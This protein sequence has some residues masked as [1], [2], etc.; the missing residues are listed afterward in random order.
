MSQPGCIMIMP[1]QGIYSSACAGQRR[2]IVLSDEKPSAECPWRRLS[3]ALSASHQSA[4]TSRDED[5]A[6]LMRWAGEAG[7]IRSPGLKAGFVEG[8]RGLVATQRIRPNSEM[9]VVPSETSLVTTTDQPCPFPEYVGRDFWAKSQWY[10]RLALLLL[11]EKQMGTE[12]KLH[13]WISRLPAAF[14]TPIAWSASELSELQYPHLDETVG[15]QRREWAELHGSLTATSPACGITEE[16]LSWAMGV[17]YSRAFR[18]GPRDF[19]PYEG[20]GPKERL[21]ELALVAVLAGGYLGLGFGDAGQVANGALAVLI[22][23]PLRDF[24]TTKLSQLKRYALTPVVDLLNHD[25]GVE[26]DVSYNYFYGHFAV[27]TTRGWEA[28]EQVLISYGP[29]SNDELLQRYGFVE[30]DNPNDVYRIT[31]LLNKLS[32]LVGEESVRVL[33]GSGEVL[34]A[35]RPVD[36]VTLGRRGL[37]GAEEEAKV[38]PAFR[39]AVVR[40]DQLPQGKAAQISLKD[41]SNE[42]SPA[43]ERAARRTLR[44]LCIK[45]RE[46]FSTSIDEDENAISSVDKS[47]TANKGLALAFRIEKKKVLDAAIAALTYDIDTES[48][49]RATTVTTSTPVAA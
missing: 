44:E 34:G 22:G 9:V 6:D 18:R 23:I 35:S 41:F 29:R 28:G 4:A 46:G 38:M 16:E 45:E 40:D 19:G 30:A 24:L 47:I 13:P 5:L 7:G 42:I 20:R 49:D 11:R 43:N 3:T 12:S 15:E 27:T 32:A 2:P 31:G 25:S 33:R 17:A 37:V 36:A 8:L 10:V 26:S 48:G 21:I 14:G 39:L 1:R